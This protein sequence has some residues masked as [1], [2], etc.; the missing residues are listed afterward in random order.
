MN[1]FDE[2]SDDFGIFTFNN[3]SFQQFKEL[4]LA[5]TFTKNPAIFNL[6][7]CSYDFLLPA[8]YQTP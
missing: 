3:N 4:L 2:L 5:I 1:R 7:F 8:R 6:Y